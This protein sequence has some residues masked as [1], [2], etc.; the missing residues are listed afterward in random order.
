MARRPASDE[1]QEDMFGAP[2]PVPAAVEPPA[3]RPSRAR[4]AP[5][6]PVPERFPDD[7]PMREEL[8][9]RLDRLSP[10]ELRVLVAA[11]SDETLAGLT[12]V[13]IRQLR[14]RLA[15]E[16]RY[17]SKGRASVLQRA[18]QQLVSELGEGNDDPD[19]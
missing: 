1:R 3:A 11:V 9:T 2:A 19:F 12:L 18:A 7:A 17:G 15:R 14:R 10:S 6:R 4:P 16:G 5:P 13:A 8:E